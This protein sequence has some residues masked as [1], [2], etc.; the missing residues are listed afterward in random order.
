MTRAEAAAALAEAVGNLGDAMNACQPCDEEF[1]ALWK[2]LAAYDAA[3]GDGWRPI[4]TAPRDGTPI[5]VCA[6][7]FGTRQISVCWLLRG[8][9]MGGP[10]L[11]P[12]WAPI[13]WRP[14][15]PPPADGGE[16]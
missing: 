2:A 12:S 15:P 1:R 14:L 13:A 9:W 10:A 3:E 8:G 6:E 4:A 16:G 11:V 7:L 5:L